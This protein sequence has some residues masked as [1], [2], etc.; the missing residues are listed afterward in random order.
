MEL[1]NELTATLGALDIFFQSHVN[2][3]FLQFSIDMIIFKE[4]VEH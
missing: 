4:P 2:A 3:N 1:K